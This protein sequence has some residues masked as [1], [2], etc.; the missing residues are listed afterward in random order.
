MDEI[1]FYVR[2]GDISP[3]EHINDIFAK[4][5]GIR[6]TKIRCKNQDQASAHFGELPYLFYG[7]KFVPRW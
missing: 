6:V 7:S 4:L 3:E 2:I 5:T 1:I